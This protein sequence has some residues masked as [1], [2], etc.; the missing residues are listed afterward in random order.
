MEKSMAKTKE[1]KENKRVTQKEIMVKNG[2]KYT[3]IKLKVSTKVR[4]K[5]Y[6]DVL[7]SYEKA[8]L[9]LIKNMES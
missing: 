2:D 9:E 8:I 6:K 5:L 3:S 7:G 4:L 1:I